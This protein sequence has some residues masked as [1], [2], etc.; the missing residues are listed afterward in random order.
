MNLF[1]SKKKVTKKMNL[2][3]V[4]NAD[5]AKS[6]KEVLPDNTAWAIIFF[7]PNKEESVV[8][9]LANIPKR[10]VHRVWRNLFKEW[11]NKYE[12]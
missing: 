11:R 8:R 4:D 12:I 1:K 10:H 7:E 5:I 3:A 2:A 6:L 9:Y